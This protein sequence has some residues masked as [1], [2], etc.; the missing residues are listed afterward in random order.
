MFLAFVC[1]YVQGYIPVVKK[2]SLLHLFDSWSFYHLLI[3]LFVYLHIHMIFVAPSIIY[4]AHYLN[5]LYFLCILSFGCCFLHNLLVHSVCVEKILT[6]GLE[7]RGGYDLCILSCSWPCCIFRFIHRLQ[8]LPMEVH[9]AIWKIASPS[10]IWNSRPIIMIPFLRCPKW[11]VGL[12]TICRFPQRVFVWCE[13]MRLDIASLVTVSYFNRSSGHLQKVCPKDL[14]SCLKLQMTSL[15]EVGGGGLLCTTS[16]L[17]FLP[18]WSCHL[19]HE[20]GGLTG[21]SWGLVLGGNFYKQLGVNNIFYVKGTFPGAQMTFFSN[22]ACFS[23]GNY[24]II[25]V[26]MILSSGRLLKTGCL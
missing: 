24:V 26:W 14:Q 25:L 22:S 9:F 19:R 1:W 7:L 8:D 10:Y 4:M 18:L 23:V 13:V 12:S 17:L 20:Y 6:T 11:G 2:D 5:N 3:L 21:G 15:G 16:W